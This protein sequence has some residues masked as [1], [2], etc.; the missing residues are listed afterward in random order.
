MR[1]S[2][3]LLVA[4][5]ACGCS[6]DVFVAA[7]SG[8]ADAGVDGALC[9]T[10][11]LM[12]PKI[13]GQL[14]CDDFDESMNIPAQWSVDTQTPGGIGVTATDWVSCPHALVGD[15]PVV[16]ATPVGNPPPHAFVRSI[17]QSGAANVVLTFDVNLPKLP[18]IGTGLADGMTFVS[19]NKDQDPSWRITLEHSSDGGWFIRD[20]QGTGGGTTSQGITP[21]LGG[22]N[23]MSLTVLYDPNNGKIDLT[24]TDGSGAQ[25]NMPSIKN[26]AT[27]RSGDSPGQQIDL[28]L[29]IEA[30]LATSSEWKVRFDDVVLSAF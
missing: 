21:L 28:R 9:G 14:S 12:Q 18:A 16:S 13:T 24:Y 1:S 26:T 3:C 6:T 29:G 19:L 23:H 5:F 2:L 8:G 22:W 10:F 25:A 15:V 4:A 17:T 7:D 30:D 27:I 20:H 11:C